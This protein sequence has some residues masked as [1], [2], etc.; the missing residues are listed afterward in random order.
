MKRASR[1]TAHDVTGNPHYFMV[2]QAIYAGIGVGKVQVSS[3]VCTPNL[4]TVSPD[5]RDAALTQL[6]S[7]REERYLHQTCVRTKPDAPPEFFEDL[8]LALD[9]AGK[10]GEWHTHFHVP[11]YLEKFG[12]LL[13]SRGA[14][15][16]CLD[17]A[18][19]YSDVKHF[20]VETYAWGV[21]PPDLQQSDLA[22]GIADELKW[23][24]GTLE[25]LARQPE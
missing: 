11:I 22:T 20:E 3:A 1:I 8:P 23:Y 4:D 25:A 12:H 21:L 24:I 14:I 2:R 19:K 16:E 6:A 13:A 9:C 15:L 17:A 7:F 18:R 5:V 10:R